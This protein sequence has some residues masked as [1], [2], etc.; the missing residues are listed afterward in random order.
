MSPMR[1][2]R[3]L[4]AAVLLAVLLP[5]LAARAREDGVPADAPTRTFVSLRVNAIDRGETVA[6]LSGDDVMVATS[7]L[8]KA[9]VPVATATHYKL[10]DD[11]FVLLRSL[12]PKI[13][14][15][16][17][18]ENL[19]VDITLP[20]EFYGTKTIELLQARPESFMYSR[21][22]SAFLNY[23]ITADTG[24]GTSYFTETGATLGAGRIYT[25]FSDSPALGFARGLTNLT[26]D[27]PEYMRR[28]V[29]GDALA[30][31]G[32]L[33]GNPYLAG[34]QIGRAFDLN[35]YLVRFPTLGFSGSISAP[36]RADVYING[37]L[38]RSIP[39]QPGQFN[40][41]G[42][43][44][45]SGA[46][47]TQIVI[48][49]SLGR[50]TTI[51]GPYY[52][53][54]SLLT[55]G[56]TDYQYSA[57]FLRPNAFGFNDTYGPFAYVGG[58]RLG[59]TDSLTLGAR[60][61][62]TGRLISGGP[63]A[64]IGT[65]LGSFHVGGA[66]SRSGGIKGAAYDAGY[67][68][69][70]R[71]FGFSAAWEYES[72]GYATTTLSPFADRPV[73]TTSLSGNYALTP[74]AALSANFSHED[75]RDSG[76]IESASLY[77]GLSFRDGV[78]LNV[79]AAR[80][81]TATPFAQPSTAMEYF[82]TMLLPSHGRATS[83][84]YSTTSQGKTTTTLETQQPVPVGVGFG[85]RAALS[86]DPGALLSGEARYN[87]PIGT[88]DLTTGLP[89]QGQMASTF[90]LAGGIADVDGR[91]AL[92]R[93][94]TDSF[95]L[96]DV[97]GQSHVDVYLNGQDMGKTDRSGKLVVPDVIP[98]YDNRIGIDER[99]TSM[100]TEITND[101][102]YI[103]PGV[104]SGALVAYHVRKIV[105]FTGKLVVRT[106][107]KEIVPALGAFDLVKGDAH[108]SSDLGDGAQFYFENLPPGKYAGTIR[109]ETGTCTFAV[110]I[111]EATQ[112]I[113]DLGTLT[114]VQR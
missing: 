56:L 17:D 3:V 97:P 72:D 92:S 95:A 49:D 61:E 113:T 11:D 69:A 65:S 60:F 114:C 62:G 4:G 1:R 64:D 93:P 91:V 90:T 31:G 77:L 57:G 20:P 14:W 52:S 67:S 39:L 106:A 29:L 63:Q 111:P 51:G 85:Y 75:Y 103:A 34:V 55:K 54:E 98:N 83:T 105:A 68:Y 27:K 33:G 45:P 46:G 87:G 37:I 96:V 73:L 53:A 76:S 109:Y 58:Y 66:L 71:R 13:T 32:D 8:A 22:R 79:G 15:S 10:F 84:G 42:I 50:S 44:P 36:G 28:T 26:F 12:D 48:T 41:Q 101:R 104:R 100:N 88:Y 110:T 112:L 16:F 89:R 18:S 74:R 6:V 5:Q 94:L 107:G 78:S 81:L 80:T 21:D 86:N 82:V 43:A 25:S 40:L 7:A 23:S 2:A 19:S 102:N 35:P 38:V 47:N 9:G 30:T 24:I 108:A 59:L 99:E 70:G